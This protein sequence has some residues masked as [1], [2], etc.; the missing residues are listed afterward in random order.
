MINTTRKNPQDNVGW[1]CGS[2]G[3]LI[4]S[5]DD[6]WVEWLALEDGSG[7]SVLRGVR[8]VHC[9]T[10][11]GRAPDYSCRY[12][13]R[14][15]FSRNEVIA[16]P[17]EVTVVSLAG[18]DYGIAVP[19]LPSESFG[20]RFAGFFRECWR[21]MRIMKD[22]VRKCRAPSH[23]MSL[24]GLQS[25]DEREVTLMATITDEEMR[26]FKEASTLAIANFREYELVKIGQLAKDLRTIL[27]ASKS[28]LQRAR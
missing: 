4:T 25:V 6:G 3:Q 7:A 27:E 11:R 2:C 28:R 14:K 18:R 26:V 15:E 1:R 13:Y 19:N 22:A 12:D 21:K 9:G 24:Y 20:R 8:L 10:V 17:V 16:S 5:I 23:L